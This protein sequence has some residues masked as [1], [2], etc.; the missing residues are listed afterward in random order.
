MC[1]KNLKQ[2]REQGK[3]VSEMTSR[4]S[5]CFHFS[6]GSPGN[7]DKI[8]EYKEEEEDIEEGGAERGEGAEGG[9]GAQRGG[10][11]ER[12]RSRETS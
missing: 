7:Q 6:S 5:L 10:G 4:L 11:A 12:W 1:E 2:T 8:E 9:G 3:V